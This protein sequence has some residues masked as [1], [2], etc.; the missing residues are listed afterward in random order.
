MA[1]SWPISAEMGKKEDN[2]G[3]VHNGDGISD[4]SKYTRSETPSH[5]RGLRYMLS[6]DPRACLLRR[7][8]IPSSRNDSEQDTMSAKYFGPKVSRKA[9]ASLR[10]EREDGVAGRM[11]WQRLGGQGKAEHAMWLQAIVDPRA[12]ACSSLACHAFGGVQPK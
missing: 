4:N 3:N 9:R 1:F 5:F 2:V 8:E 10:K 6:E 7:I 12:A 11:V